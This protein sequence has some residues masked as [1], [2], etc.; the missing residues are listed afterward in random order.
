MS[1]MNEAEYARIL[2]YGVGGVSTT[3]VNIILF[4]LLDY[5]LPG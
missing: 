5:L 1:R 3:L 4:R 2:R